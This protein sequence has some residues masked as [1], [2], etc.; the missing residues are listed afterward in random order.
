MLTM[1]QNVNFPSALY[2][3]NKE[4]ESDEGEGENAN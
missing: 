3:T 4:L 2:I 1:S